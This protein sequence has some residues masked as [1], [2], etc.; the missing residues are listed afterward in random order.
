MKLSQFDFQYPKELIAQYPL[1]K[2]EARLLV[3]DRRT[4]ELH[5]TSFFHVLDFLSSD[6]CLVVNETQVIPA[7][8]FARKETGAYVEVLLLEE[9]RK[10]VWKCTGSTSKNLKA[11]SKLIFQEGNATILE[12]NHGIFVLEFFYEG[13]WKEWLYKYGHVPLPLYI[14]RKDQKEDVENY[15]TVFAKNP[16]AIAAPTA[17]LHWTD[18]LLACFKKKGGI[19]APITLHVGY[20]TFSPIREEN[21]KNHQMHRE[22]FEISPESSQK[23]NEAKRVVCV[24]TTTV[25]ALESATQGKKVLASSR[26][27]DLYIYPGYSFKRVDLLQTNFHQPKS[28]LLLMVSAFAGCEFISRCY[29]EAIEQRYRLF[30]YGDTLLLL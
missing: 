15:Q 3:A 30:S 14:G 23:I 2:G 24:G 26:W 9:L 7:R 22:F 16:G 17:G 20:G 4:K 18:E 21:I 25:R 11:G 8:L 6:D 12:V 28:S 19:I 1:K 27:T 5:H 29:Q 13:E 10:N